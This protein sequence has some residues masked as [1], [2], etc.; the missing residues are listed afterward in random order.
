VTTPSPDPHIEPMTRIQ[1][2][3]AMG[4]TAIVLLVVSKVW[5]LFDQVSLL[6][7]SFTPLALLT[8]FAVGL[9]ISGASAIAYHF[10]PSYRSSAEFYM[11]LVIQ[12]LLFPDLL[13]LGLLPG[14][15]EELLFR[16]VMLPAFGLNWVGIT[17]TSLLF[18]VLHFS[19]TQKWAYVIWASVIGAILGISAVESGNL[20]IPIVAH[21]ATNLI[22][23]VS[24]K[25]REV[26]NG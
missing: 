22:S 21:I 19:G 8:G 23:S 12:P 5:L 16:G 3:A 9:G 11:S 10:W 7:F 18:G 25:M 13:W 14:L 15:S 2:L 4:I 20:L 17:L 26:G 1:V 24:W 6:P